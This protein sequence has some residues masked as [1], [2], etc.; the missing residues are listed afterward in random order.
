MTIYLAYALIVAYFVT[1]RTLRQGEEAKSVSAGGRDRHSSG[2]L[3]F[4]FALSCLAMIGAPFLSS[5]HMD[6]IPGLL[7]SLGLVLM[8]AGILLRSSANRTLG[9]FYS[10]TLRVSDDQKL[11]QSGPYLW[12]RH[13]GYAGSLLL[14]LGAGLASTHAF[15]LLAIL[16]VTGLAY[17]YRIRAEEKMLSSRFGDD[18]AKYRE[19][20]WRLIPFVY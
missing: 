16:V 6:Q 20:T 11:V 12:I 7:P 18:F 2:G 14:W 15:I 17:S 13:P 4:A 3:G 5:V 19:R 1:E 10:R 9:E 8:A